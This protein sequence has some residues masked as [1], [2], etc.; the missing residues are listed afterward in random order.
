MGAD[1]VGYPQSSSICA[2]FC[3]RLSLSEHKPREMQSLIELVRGE[4]VLVGDEVG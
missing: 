3:S 2:Q 1:T 4:S